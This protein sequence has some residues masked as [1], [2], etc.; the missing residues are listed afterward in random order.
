MKI[1]IACIGLVLLTFTGTCQGIR[2]YQSGEDTDVSGTVIDFTGTESLQYL[3]FDVKNESGETLSLRIT[4]LKVIEL[5]ETSDYLCWEDICYSVVAVSAENPWTTPDEFELVDSASIEF[6]G[7]HVTNS[8][9]GCVQY[10]YYVIDESDS[11][12]DSVDIKFCSTVGITENDQINISVFPNPASEKLT[13]ALDSKT[14]NDV[15]FKMYNSTG[16]ILIL[17]KL[18]EGQNRFNTQTLSSGFYFYVILY[19]GNVLEAKKIAV[20]H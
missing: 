17:E 2:I 11:K 20:V 19:E 10:R 9:A 7:Y 18:N 5:E 12:L 1:I 16:D 14:N 4:R 3:T 13:V 6:S 15:D 8:K